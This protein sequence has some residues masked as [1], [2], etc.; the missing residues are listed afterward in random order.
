VIIAVCGLVH[1]LLQAKRLDESKKMIGIRVG[2]WGV[3]M[4]IEV[5]GNQ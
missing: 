4:K 1:V 3:D 2:D 5:S